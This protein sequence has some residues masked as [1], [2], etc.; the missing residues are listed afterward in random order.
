MSLG[1]RMGALICVRLIILWLAE[2]EVL[3]QALI[4]FLRLTFIIWLL[5]IIL[6]MIL[7]SSFLYHEKFNIRL[8][9]LKSGSMIIIMSWLILIKCE[10]EVL[11]WRDLATF[12][13][14]VAAALLRKQEILWLATTLF[15]VWVDWSNQNF[16][17]FT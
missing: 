7:F 15:M 12:L 5:A 1:L 14:S 6:K 3:M 8:M 16:S 9:S 17:F 10:I 13:I 2:L 11:R 4:S